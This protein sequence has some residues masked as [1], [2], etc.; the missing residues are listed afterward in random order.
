ML[1]ENPVQNQWLDHPLFEE[2]EVEVAIKRLDLIH[3]VISG[4]KFY[5]LNYNLE[6]AL[7]TNK[8]IILTFG[9]A[10]SNHISAVALAAKVAGLKSIGIIRG[11]KVMPLNPT[12]EEAESNGMHLHFISRESYRNKTQ[13]DFMEELKSQFDD[14]Y[15]IPEG[16][17]N[18]LAIQG[19]NEILKET[20]SIFSHI[21]TP[22]GTGG[23]FAGLSKSLEK[24]QNLLGVSS[25]KGK[26]IHSEIENLLTQ[27]DISPKGNFKILDQYH[28]GGYAKYN[29]ELI[30]FIWSFFEDF[31]IILDPIYTSKMAFAAWDLVATN[32]FSKGSKILLLH[33]GGLQGN[34]GFTNRT[35]IKLPDFSE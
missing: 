21:F 32:H 30:E 12:L 14:F 19:T 24:G 1:L 27:Y 16:G 9:G 35:G 31:G 7:K 18:A 20:D 10:Y 26:F 2:K 34:K 25:L 29:Q 17:T 4:N 13:P 15:L 22:I 33:T 28:F 23:T 3:P 6:E 8:N 5:K 11:E